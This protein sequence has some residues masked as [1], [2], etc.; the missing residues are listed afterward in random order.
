MTMRR[1]FN[2]LLPREQPGPEVFFVVGHP[3]SGTNWICNL[4]N[5]HP[6]VLCDGEFHFHEIYQVVERMS[7]EPWRGAAKEPCRSALRDG[8]ADMVRRT[9]L[10]AG[11][12]KPG[13]RRIGDRTPR[14][15]VPLIPG[16]RH[17]VCVRDGRDVLVSW[18]FHMLK[19]GGPWLTRGPFG[20]EMARL[21]ED[22]DADA[23][24]F[25]RDPHRLLS[26]ESWLRHY[27]QEWSQRITADLE[28][29]GK[30]EADPGLGS[31]YWVAYER[32]H[33]DVESECSRLYRYLDV[34]PRLAK[35]AAAEAHTRPGYTENDPR[36][37]FRSGRVGDWRRFFAEGQ[38]RTFEEL[39]GGALRAV[40]AHAG[41]CTTPGGSN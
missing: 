41:T 1:L 18:T 24:L 6:H 8:F 38:L 12:R 33:A 28:M 26:V 27:A 29:T 3:R 14:H 16:C 11:A 7:E 39:A 40:A 15:L 21:K 20:P 9:L 35:A 4:L 34:E 31:A 17:V 32:M 22:F 2:S 36:S 5:L 25:E 10:A 30:M 23:M 19:H 37:F 13:A